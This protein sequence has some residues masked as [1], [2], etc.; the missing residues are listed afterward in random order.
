MVRIC[1]ILVLALLLLA[2]GCGSADKLAANDIVNELKE[3]GIEL[4]SADVKETIELKGVRPHTFTIRKTDE[5]SAD[6]ELLSIYLFDSAS[7]RDQGAD[8]FTRSR[9]SYSGLQPLIY[10]YRNALI[11]YW[12][13]MVVNQ[14][15]TKFGDALNSVL[16]KHT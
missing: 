7:K 6:P 5:D 9:Q 14:S 8:E 10:K 4:A 1:S 2:A 16:N 3:Q 11:L 13:R 15:E 12:P